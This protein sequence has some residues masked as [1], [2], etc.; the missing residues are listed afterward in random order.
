MSEAADSS[1][2]RLQR[3]RRGLSVRRLRAAGDAARAAGGDQGAAP[4]GER[5]PG[6]VP[7][8]EAGFGPDGGG[9]RGADGP[10]RAPPG[11]APEVATVPAPDEGALLT[12]AR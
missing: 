12:V 6:H 4:D 5:R 7:P 8:A 9:G 3:C 2:G 1:A 10:A 11:P